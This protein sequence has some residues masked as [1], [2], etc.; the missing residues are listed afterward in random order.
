MKVLG[1]KTKQRLVQTR[2]GDLA[3]E[4]NGPPEEEPE[5]QYEETPQVCSHCGTELSEENRM[6]ENLLRC[7][8]PDCERLIYLE[9]T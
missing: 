5:E 9:L 6:A 7:P 4:S 3:F 1:S 8:N 2:H